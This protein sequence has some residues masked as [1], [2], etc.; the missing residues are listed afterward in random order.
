MSIKQVIK[1]ELETSFNTLKNTNFWLNFLGVVLFVLVINGNTLLAIFCLVAMLFLKMKLD[2]ESG[3]IM[4]YY[5]KKHNIPNKTEIRK[6][7]EKHK[8][9]LTI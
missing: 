6:I 8:R 5:R 3:E 7:K 4:A 2:H 9:D 1:Y